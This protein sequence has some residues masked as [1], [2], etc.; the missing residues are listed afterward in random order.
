[1]R[2][3]GSPKTKKNAELVI[4]DSD[5]TADE[6]GCFFTKMGGKVWLERCPF[7]KTFRSCRFDILLVHKRVVF[8]LVPGRSNITLGGCGRQ[9]Q[10]SLLINFG[11]Y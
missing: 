5:V 9:L 4:I 3:L 11:S 8:Q 7:C 10:F 2:R 6:F 1:M